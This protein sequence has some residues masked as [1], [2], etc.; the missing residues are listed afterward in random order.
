V[1][2]HGE[3]S[4]FEPLE[5]V[6][7]GYESANID[8]IAE[9]K[10]ALAQRFLSNNPKDK[11]THGKKLDTEK[12][13]LRAMSASSTQRKGGLDTKPKVKP[14]PDPKEKAKLKKPEVVKET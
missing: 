7:E 10:L 4:L 1:Q 5:P 11:G 12:P 2:E 14:K 3:S 6:P 9:R 13:V 8:E